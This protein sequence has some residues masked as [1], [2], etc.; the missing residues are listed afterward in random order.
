MAA[1]CFRMAFAIAILAAGAANATA[2][3]YNKA[4]APQPTKQQMS[5]KGEFDAMVQADVFKRSSM[6]TRGT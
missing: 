2:Q 5:A 3:T 4:T 1:R 6:A